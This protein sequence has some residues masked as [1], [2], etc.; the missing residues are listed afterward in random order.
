MAASSSQNNFDK[1]NHRSVAREFKVLR[2]TRQK[3]FIEFK[4][5][6][7]LKTGDFSHAW[8]GFP[9]IAPRG[10]ESGAEVYEIKKPQLKIYRRKVRPA[11]QELGFRSEPP[12]ADQAADQPFYRPKFRLI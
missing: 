1:L 9:S 10:R 12:I 4:F 8:G 7:H 6:G 3:R 2:E 5:T 11:E